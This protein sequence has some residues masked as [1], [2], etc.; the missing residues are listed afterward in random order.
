LLR[1]LLSAR[2]QDHHQIGALTQLA[3]FRSIPGEVAC[4]LSMSGA[5]Y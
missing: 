3:I 5:K 1:I 4:F 2:C